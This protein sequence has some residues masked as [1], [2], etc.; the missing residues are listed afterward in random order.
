[1]SLDFLKEAIRE[2]ATSNQNYCINKIEKIVDRLQPF[3]NDVDQNPKQDESLFVFI[4]YRKG[5]DM[6]SY[7]SCSEIVKYCNDID[8]A[9]AENR[10]E[11]L[12][13]W[14]EE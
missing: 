1:M 11:K 8:I 6:E 7:S 5:S 4:Y 13:N 3:V 10:F 2:V 14:Y 12:K 9:L